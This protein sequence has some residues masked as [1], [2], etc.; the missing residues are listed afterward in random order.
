MTDHGE[1]R[2]SK[3]KRKRNDE[4][5]SGKVWR[6]KC[7]K[8]MINEPFIFESP[9]IV[10][11]VGVGCRETDS[12][13]NWGW[14]LW[15]EN[16]R[17]NHK[18]KQFATDVR[19]ISFPFPRLVSTPSFSLFL[20]PGRRT[21]CTGVSSFLG[22]VPTSLKNQ[23]KIK[24]FIFFCLHLRIFRL[25]DWL[26][27]ALKQISLDFHVCLSQD[28]LQRTAYSLQID[29]N[30]AFFKLKIRLFLIAPSKPINKL[31]ESILFLPLLWFHNILF[32]SKRF[33]AKHSSSQLNIIFQISRKFERPKPLT[34]TQ[35][36]TFALKAL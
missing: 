18:C 10:S 32:C 29:L 4:F 34:G 16:I 9:L 21:G 13:G 15:R 2:R 8:Q 35:N 17:Q 28:W 36:A 24:L 14:P 31:W 12:A 20:L 33:V 22:C 26:I 23:L 6:R 7:E 19:R 5:G 1:R 27:V 25:I 11:A 30:W 3:A